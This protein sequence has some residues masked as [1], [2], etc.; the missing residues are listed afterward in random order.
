MIRQPVNQFHISV[1]N[2]EGTVRWFRTLELLSDRETD[3][4]MGPGTRMWKVQELTRGN[5]ASSP[6]LTLKDSWAEVDRVR[7]GNVIESLRSNDEALT[8]AQYVKIVEKFFP[9]VVTHGD[10]YVEGEADRTEKLMLHNT[11]IPPDSSRY[12]LPFRSL[13]NNPKL[14]ARG[15]YMTPD[16]CAAAVASGLIL[17]TIDPPERVHYRVVFPDA[18]QPLHKISGL[19]N[20]F[21][22]MAQAAAGTC[23]IAVANLI[24]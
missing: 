12:Y 3:T 20:F 24:V 17:E 18:F 10:V 16:E 5:K 4:T 6:V 15:D 7:E 13:P 19:E 1:R 9:Q 21:Q 8:S 11:H 23:L 14:S 22:A 2:E